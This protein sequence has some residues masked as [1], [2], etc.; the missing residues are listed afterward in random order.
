M[1]PKAA[2]WARERETDILLSGTVLT[3]GGIAIAEAVGVLHPERVRVAYV[4]SMPEPKDSELRAAL[5]AYFSMEHVSGVTFGYGIYMRGEAEGCE[6][7][8]LAH[9]LRHVY[10]YEQAGSIE[11]FL[12]AYLSQVIESGYA[13]APYEIDAMIASAPYRN[14]S[15]K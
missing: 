13:E 14:G 9:E 12:A 4:R 10:Q 3:A 15:G 11:A 7:F 6:P 2:A 1:F 8:I 5:R